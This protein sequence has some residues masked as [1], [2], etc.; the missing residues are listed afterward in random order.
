[1]LAQARILYAGSLGARA[2]NDINEQ[3]K[4]ACVNP[5]TKTVRTIMSQASH[6]NTIVRMGMY[7]ARQKILAP[8]S[9]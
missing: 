8:A 3:R 1:M 9:A 7:Y 2:R 6:A 4:V 5:Q